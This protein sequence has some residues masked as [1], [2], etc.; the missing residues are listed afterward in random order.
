MAYGLVNKAVPDPITATTDTRVIQALLNK[1]IP[2]KTSHTELLFPASTHDNLFTET[3]QVDVMTGTIGMAPFN[4]IG[5][6]ASLVDALNGTSYTIQ[7]PFIN[8]QRPLQASTDFAKRTAL[9]QVFVNG[10]TNQYQEVVRKVIEQDV[11]F[12]NGLIDNRLEWMAAFILRGEI[13]YSVEGQDS[14]IINSGKPAANTFTV[15][16]L[17]DGGS[18]TPLQD[19]DSAKRI[20]SLK[21][22]PLPN[23]AICGQDASS[24]LKA[25]VEAGSI[26]PIAT[27]SGVDAVSRA[28]LL[29]RYRDNGMMFLGN[30]GDVDFFE[31]TGTYID[32]STGSETALIRSSYIEFLSTSTRSVA[33]RQ[34]LFGPIL[35]LAIIQRGEHITSRHM[36]TVMPKEDQ[37]TFQGI[38]KSRPFT[39]LRRPDWQVSMKVVA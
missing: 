32:D 27:T 31:Y 4:K 8:I 17:W 10:Q 24:A 18:A 38:M 16:N 7:T 19:I 34:L 5:Q 9:G 13:D 11:S 25:L 1:R 39:H 36:Q 14:F 22:G 23:I 35:D 6:K 28:N 37:G 2:G 15:S 3:V 26:K 30:F 12:M 20:V 33:E 29:S 21:L